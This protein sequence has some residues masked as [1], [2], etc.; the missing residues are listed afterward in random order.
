[1]QARVCRLPFNVM[2]NRC[3]SSIDLET[4]RS[5]SVT[6]SERFFG[7]VLISCKVHIKGIFISSHRINKQLPPFGGKIGI[8]NHTRDL[9]VQFVINVLN[10]S[11][12]CTRLMAR[13]ILRTL[14]SSR[15]P[16]K[17]VRAKI[18]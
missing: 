3:N 9:P 15:V 7:F 13:S 10:C 16:L 11:Q 1:M 4:C 14:R 6:V 12:N 18:F 17:D 2:L 5:L 8:G